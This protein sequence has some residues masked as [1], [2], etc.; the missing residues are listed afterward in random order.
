MDKKR[1]IY[2]LKKGFVFYALSTIATA[3]L[4]VGF[5]DGTSIA[6]LMDVEG[7]VFFI[8]SCISHASQL[9]LVPYALFVV[10][11]ALQL[12]RV[13]TITQ[14]TAATLIFILLLLDSQV[15]AIYRFHINGMILGMVFGD[16]ASQIF[17][18]DTMLYLK[19]GLRFL[20]VVAAIVLLQWMARYVLRKRG[21]AYVW[22]VALAF[23]GCTLYA[24]VWHIY[25]S[26]M[27][28][29]SVTKS[30]ALI[31]Y[32]FPTTAN[33]LLLNMGIVAPESFDDRAS[34]R[35]STDI[36]YPLHEL[37]TVKPD[38][39][40]NIVL[41]AIDSWNS[42][43]LTPE[44]MPNVYRFAEQN[45]WFTNHL[46]SS[47]GTRSSI[48]GIFFGLSCYYWESFV[49]SHVYPLFIDRLIELGYKCQTY[50]SATLLDPPFDK[51]IFGRLKGLN[52]T[53]EGD[54]VFDRDKKLTSMF[55]SDLGKQEKGKPFFSFLFYDLPHS[56]ELTAEQNK[57]FSPAWSYADYTKLNNDLDPT[58]FWNLYRNCCHQDDKMIGEVLKALD[59]GGHLDNTI[60][61]LTGDHSQELNENHRNYW[62]HNS[63]FSVNQT[64][65]PLVCHF[66]GAEAAKYKHRTTHYDIVPTLMSH[67]LGVRNPADDY[68]MGRSLHDTTPRRW[69][70]VGSNLNYA[71][72]IGGD[73]ILEKK[74]E[75]AL[76]VFDPKMKPVTDFKMPVKE[77]DEAIKNMNKFFK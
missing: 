62:G 68:S 45:Q 44:C 32:F 74:A 63:N 16:G 59:E 52:I 73:T 18:F 36:V 57:P 14:T 46:S 61:I 67:Y 34:S 2:S 17:T 30:A 41:I 26:F 19:E 38:S 22:P 58:P 12:P 77:F 31:P 49:P 39:L 53:V 40:P 24:H 25:A 7:W 3:L 69:H 29:Q 42:R 60:V 20:V 28:H 43:T 1:F 23:A 50:P 13:A 51:A 64:G 54:N 9:M 55:V 35:Q 71:F 66:P 5:I 56:F 21:K 75:G 6:E 72:I 48:F 15:Y 70:L 8:A 4:M 65:V 37:E 47:N 76:E 11:L 10:L 33:G 27:Q